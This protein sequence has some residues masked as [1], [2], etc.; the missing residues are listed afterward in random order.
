MELNPIPLS[1][2]LKDEIV[3]KFSKVGFFGK[4]PLSILFEFF[5]RSLVILIAVS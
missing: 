5:F 1:V 3:L 4:F 2:I